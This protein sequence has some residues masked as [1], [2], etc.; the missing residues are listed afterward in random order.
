MTACLML[1]GIGPTPPHIPEDEK[2]YWIT[3][4]TFAGLI[5]MVREAKAR[6]TFDDGNDSD[7]TIASPALQAAGMTAAFFIPSDRINTPGYLNEEQIQ[8]MHNAGMEIGS[9]GCAHIKWTNISD[10]EIA[11][12]VARSVERL[13]A[14]IKT[15]VR[16]L[17]IPFG[18]CDRRVLAILRKL[19]IG[20][21]YTSFRGPEAENAWLVRRD[22]IMAHM[23]RADINAVLWRKRAMA[24]SALEFLR[25][26]KHTGNAALREI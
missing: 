13:S 2:P 22:C 6:L 8:A 19:G 4:G 25:M 21:V 1:H 7:A 15:P 11:I 12:D 14:I 17:A 16:T 18:D 23:T 20:R 24:D 5:E 3:S 9:H 26:W 10:A